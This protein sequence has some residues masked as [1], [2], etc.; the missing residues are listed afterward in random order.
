MVISIVHEPSAYPSNIGEREWRENARVTPNVLV[1]EEEDAERK[2]AE[3]MP[4][5]TEDAAKNVGRTRAALLASI[6]RELRMPMNTASNIGRLLL[7]MEPA[8]QQR[9]YA[10]ALF[11]LS[12]TLLR[13]SNNLLLLSGAESGE[14]ALAHAPFSI[15]DCIK[16]ALEMVAR[17]AGRKQLTLSHAIANGTPAT[18]SGDHARLQQVLANLLA[19]AM[20]TAT[21]GEI[22]ITAQWQTRKG[23]QELLVAVHSS[24]PGFRQTS[25]ERR[26]GAS[27]N[28]STVAASQQGRAEIELEVCR[29]L[30]EKMNGRIWIEDKQGHGS[31]F[32]CTFPAK[33]VQQD[34]GHHPPALLNGKRILLVDDHDESS[35]VLGY[36]LQRLAMMPVTVPSLDIAQELV[37]Q[38]VHFDA[39]IINSTI[40]GLSRNSLAVITGTVGGSRELPVLL[41]LSPNDR[42][43]WENAMGSAPISFLE[44][45][46]TETKLIGA[47]LD[48]FLQH[49][50]P[51]KPSPPSA[52]HAGHTATHQPA[53]ALS[54]LVAEDNP[55]NQRVACLMLE[56]LGYHPDT[57]ND[58]FEVIA[59]VRQNAYD[60]VLMD[61]EMPEMN[62]LKATAAIRA[63]LPAD[64]Q[65]WIIAM[66]ADT[67]EGYRDRCAE[68]GMDGYIIKPISRKSLEEA[69]GT[70]SGK[71]EIAPPDIRSEAHNMEYLESLR[72]ALGTESFQALNELIDQYLTNTAESIVYLRRKYAERNTTELS[73]IAHSLKASSMI[74]GAVKL[75]ELFA[76]LEGA[77]RTS[78][79]EL[80]ED[81]L[82]AIVTEFHL[83]G[84]RLEG[85][86]RGG[87]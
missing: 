13:L 10:E 80:V 22:T 78:A 6:S 37:L 36:Q 33:A 46:S 14:L 9:N 20:H 24:A 64:R 68:A 12:D 32:W 58:G 74:F 62:G 51:M 34:E 26:L 67:I 53:P 11:A 5:K 75:A 16:G 31:I 35:T 41:L 15:E 19:T 86:K 81:L 2:Q 56:Q 71:Q 50:T 4:G 1:Q 79:L 52:A 47:L 69:L 49:P 39:A 73:R 25:D 48:L 3:E 70:R 27:G 60:I 8:P 29:M 18:I 57:A 55:V 61:V 87:Y 72:K 85:E 21:H 76:K 45:P 77:G 63:E 42:P 83:T 65:P 43:L 17:E 54:I 7:V 30:V 59:A 66:T 28:P 38:G 84:K 44:S 23:D 40:R 82:S